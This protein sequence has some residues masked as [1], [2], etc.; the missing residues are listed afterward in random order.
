MKTTIQK[1]RGL[2]ADTLKI[3][4]RGKPVVDGDT[5]GAL[6]VKEGDFLVIMNTLKKP[7]PKQ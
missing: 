7:E 3:V 6:G 1:E 4:Y 5:V 2:A